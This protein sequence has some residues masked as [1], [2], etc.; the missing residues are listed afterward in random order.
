MYG[1]PVFERRDAPKS[2]TTLTKTVYSAAAWVRG[3]GASL[4]GGDA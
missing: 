4:K 2:I 3:H 1:T